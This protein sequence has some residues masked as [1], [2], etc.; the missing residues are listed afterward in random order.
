MDAY[1]TDW[2]NLALRWAHMIT[3]IAWVGACVLFRLAGQPP[4]TSLFDPAD[5]A[6]G[7]GGE[8]WAVHGGGF[9]TAKRI[10]RG[11][12]RLPPLLHPG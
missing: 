7:I 2:L 11:A 9:Y 8:L 10:H 4:R 12:A 6:K 5:E 3:G 1:L